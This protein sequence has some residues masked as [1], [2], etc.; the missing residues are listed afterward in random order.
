MTKAIDD[1]LIAERVIAMLGDG[2]GGLAALM[3]GIR[4]VR[5]PG[6][7]DPAQRTREIG[8]RI[9][10]GRA[11]AGRWVRLILREVM[12]L[13]GVAMLVTIR[14]DAGNRALSG[15]SWFGVSIAD[16]R[17]V[18]AG[19]VMIWPNGGAGGFIPARRA[20]TVDPA[21]ALRDRL[22]KPVARVGSAGR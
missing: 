6:V 19:I 2:V 17:R 11:A 21:R 9:G 5:N 22:R 3:A 16:P 14:G 13:A 1:N 4:S 10:A 18:W 7:F 20:A 15:A 12:V 8:I